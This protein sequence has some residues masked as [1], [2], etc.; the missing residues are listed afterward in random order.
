M[1]YKNEKGSRTNSMSPGRTLA[2]FTRTHGSY[3]THSAGVNESLVR[4]PLQILY[5]Q[6]YA[7]LQKKTKVLLTTSSIR[8]V[9]YDCYC[10][11]SRGVYEKNKQPMPGPSSLHAWGDHPCKNAAK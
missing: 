8:G 5:V 3:G 4:K 10:W 6:Y 1:V 7:L 9:Q 11:I 2:L